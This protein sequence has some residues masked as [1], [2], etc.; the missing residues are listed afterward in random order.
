MHEQVRAAQHLGVT[1]VRGGVALKDVDTLVRGRLADVD[2][3]FAHGL[4]HGVGLRIHEDPF[5]RPTSDGRLAAGVVVTVEPGVYVA[6][7]GG[8]RIEDTLAVTPDGSL[9]LTGAPHDLIDIL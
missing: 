4:G 3:A 5:F 1:A 7:R 2:G 9:N 6:N 8:V